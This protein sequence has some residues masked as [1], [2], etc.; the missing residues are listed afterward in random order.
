PHLFAIEQELL[1]SR[2]GTLIVPLLGNITNSGH[3]RYIFDRFRPE[4]I[5]HAAAHKH[6]PMM[7]HQPAEAIRNNRPVPEYTPFVASVADTSRSDTRGSLTEGSVDVLPALSRM[8]SEQ[9]GCCS[10]GYS[11]MN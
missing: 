10:K 9:L 4:V 7:E 6:V 3:M 2:S 8:S 5:F 1:A 11:D